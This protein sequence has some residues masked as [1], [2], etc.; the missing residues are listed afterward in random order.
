MKDDNDECMEVMMWWSEKETLSGLAQLRLLLEYPGAVVDQLVNDPGHG[1]HATDDGAQTAG[2]VTEG[3]LLLL[4][5][6]HDGRHLVREEDPG[7]SR[8][9][10][11]TAD[12]GL[13]VSGDTELVGHECTSIH[14]GKCGGN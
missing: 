4:I 7:H 8:V 10:H 3:L 13:V 1:E 14:S 5:L 12:D 11:Q 9:S 2:K 6:D